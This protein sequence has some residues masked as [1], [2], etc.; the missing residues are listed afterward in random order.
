[1]K[2]GD[3]DKDEEDGTNIM[4][5]KSPLA[6]GSRI[7]KSH[8]PKNRHSTH[9]REQ[10][11]RMKKG[12]RHG[13]EIHQCLNA[14]EGF[15]KRRSNY[16]K[17]KYSGLTEMR[18]EEGA[19]TLRKSICALIRQ[20]ICW[21]PEVRHGGQTWNERPHHAGTQTPWGRV[22]VGEQFPNA[23]SFLMIKVRQTDT[24]YAE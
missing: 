10:T 12:T 6:A 22:A 9:R 24:R 2:K 13:K 11:P 23:K 3:Y 5:P 16:L 20:E 19:S 4:A 21:L 15:P 7:P 8:G 1:V 18:W 17:W 14:T